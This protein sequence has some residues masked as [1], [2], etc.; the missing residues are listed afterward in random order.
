[1]LVV[2][3]VIGI[4]LGKVGGGYLF[5]LLGLVELRRYC[6][7]FDMRERWIVVSLTTRLLDDQSK[8]SI[9]A[10]GPELAAN[11]FHTFSFASLGLAFGCLVTCTLPNHV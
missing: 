8:G 9:S 5:F 1:M 11:E 10:D 2:E 3:G 7:S 6:A 4:D